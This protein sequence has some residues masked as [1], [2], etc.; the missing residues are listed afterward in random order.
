MVQAA[1]TVLSAPAMHGR[2][3]RL[4]MPSRTS[5]GTDAGR[6]AQALLLGGSSGL[7]VSQIIDVANEA[8]LTGDAPWDSSS[9]AKRS[10]VST[11]IN[12]AP[13]GFFAVLAR[14]TYAHLAFPGVQERAAQHAAQAQADKG[15]KAGGG[16]P[17]PEGSGPAPLPPPPAHGG[18]PAARGLVPQ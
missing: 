5:R 11:A 15:K 9:R 18:P 6:R 1:W 10:S 13:P 4:W 14:A 17:A 3:A 7:K 16:A 12:S 2:A 8:G